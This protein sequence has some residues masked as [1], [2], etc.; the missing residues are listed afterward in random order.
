MSIF[1]KR[2]QSIFGVLAAC[3]FL[4]APSVARA[5]QQTLTIPAGTMLNVRMI[6]SISS[7]VN[8][9]GQI[10]RGSLDSPVIVGNRTVL[11]KGATV[12]V[13]LVSARSAGRVKGRSELALQL[14]SIVLRGRLYP[15]SSRIVDFRGKSESKKSLK[16]AGVGAAV[17]GGLGALLGGGS[18]AAVGAGLGAGTGVAV[19]AANPGQQVRI[20][21]ESLLRFRLSRPLRFVE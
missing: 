17:G 5:D 15:I 21:T 7:D 13:K 10:F 16:N 18:G 4:L 19:N 12:H 8:H 9:A 1:M 14:D 6:D 20:G 3:V 11:P 2:I